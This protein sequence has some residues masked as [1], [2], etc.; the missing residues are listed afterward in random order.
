VLLEGEPSYINRYELRNSANNS[1]SASRK[2][3]TEKADASR[4]KT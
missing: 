3:L 2:N 4:S 1:R